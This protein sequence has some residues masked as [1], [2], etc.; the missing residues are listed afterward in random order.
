[1][2][3]SMAAQRQPSQ[4][5]LDP[6][7]AVLLLCQQQHS[8]TGCFINSFPTLAALHQ[9]GSLPSCS[10]VGSDT[11]PDNCTGASPS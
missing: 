9:L 11:L 1:M 4:R 8:S 5:R 2:R 6:T 10:P 3:T 7:A